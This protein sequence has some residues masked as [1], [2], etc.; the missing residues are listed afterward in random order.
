MQAEKR[1]TIAKDPTL[2]SLIKVL[3]KIRVMTTKWSNYFGRYDYNKGYGQ[4]LLNQLTSFWRNLTLFMD[5]FDVSHKLA[6]SAELTLE[7]RMP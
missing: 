2:V 3:H 5:Y 7:L 6:N 4:I 1:W